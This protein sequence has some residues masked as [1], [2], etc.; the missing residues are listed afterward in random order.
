[1]KDQGTPCVW[2][3]EQYTRQRGGLVALRKGHVNKIKEQIVYTHMHKVTSFNFN[4]ENSCT[5]PH[6][7]QH[8]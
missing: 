1:M 2:L 5:N 8:K 3:K 7:T 6:L 4:N